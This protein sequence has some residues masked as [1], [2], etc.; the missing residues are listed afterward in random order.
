VPSIRAARFGQPPVIDGQL[1]EWS[2]EPFDLQYVVFGRPFWTGPADLSGRGFAG[3]DEQALYLAVRVEDDVH[4]QPARGDRLYL[5]DSLE[6]QIDAD[7][8]GDWDS[9]VHSEDDWHMGVSPGD[10]AGRAPEA[11][12]W[13]PVLRAVTG[14]PIGAVPTDTGYTIELALPWSVIGFDP[15]TKAGLGLALNASD[16]DDPLPAQLT[17]TSSSPQ[18]SWSDPRTFNTLVL[19]P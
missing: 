5:G 8:E 7:L 9:S 1:D 16:N 6:L 4:S 3:W 19:E 18:R 11:Y 13:R 14:M 17:M 10:F 15:T 2:S 12:L